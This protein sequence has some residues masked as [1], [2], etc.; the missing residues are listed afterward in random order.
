MS[1][2]LK[3]HERRREYPDL[4]WYDK[5]DIDDIHKILD[6]GFSGYNSGCQTFPH[7]DNVIGID[8]SSEGYDGLHLPYEDNSFDVIYSSHMIEDVPNPVDY[9]REHFRCVK[10]YGFLI[11]YLPHQWLYERKETPPSNWNKCH[12]HFYTPAKFLGVVEEALNIRS[13]RLRQ[14]QDC[15]AGY[16][17]SIPDDQ[18]AVGEYSIEVV[19]EKI[20]SI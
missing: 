7:I 14:C 1:E 19:L 9:I 2:T 12:S 10:K 3:A 6:I 16:D 13:Y 4:N 8:F 11:Y 15:D 20:I 5:Y 18:H 17:N